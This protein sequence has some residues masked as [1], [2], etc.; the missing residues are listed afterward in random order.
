MKR[1]CTKCNKKLPLTSFHKDNNRP[2]GFLSNC[3]NC[4]KSYRMKHKDKEKVTRQKWEQKSRI[5][6]D[7]SWW[8]KI[9]RYH[10]LDYVKIKSIFEKQNKKCFY[11]KIELSYKNLHI[12]HYYPK[13]ND[14]IVIACCDCNR[15]KWRRNG[16]EFINFLKEYITRFS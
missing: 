10:H 6:M 12:E 3:V 14:K 7:D 9:S 2:D 5:S 4:R 16:D 13:K 8:R 11:C 15:L 1:T